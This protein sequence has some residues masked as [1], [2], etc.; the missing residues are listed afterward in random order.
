MIEFFLRAPVRTSVAIGSLALLAG[1]GSPAPRQE[2]RAGAYRIYATNEV[3]G[4]LSIIDPESRSVVGRIPLGKRPRGIMPSPDGRLLYVALSGSPIGGPG[5]AEDSLPPAD[6]AADGIAVIDVA[7]GKVKQVLRGI[8]DPEQ[9]AVSPDG[10]RLYVASEDSGKL[11]VIGA[12]GGVIAKVAVGD[13][14]EGVA[15]SPDGK[16]V[17]VTSEADSAVA[18][19]DADSGTITSHVKVGKRP[20]NALFLPDGGRAWVSGE[21]DG[22]VSLI[23]VTSGRLVRQVRLE[24]DGARPMDI[25]LSPDGK[26]LYVTTGRGKQLVRIDTA[27]FRQTGAVEVGDR[28]WGMKLSPDGRFAFTANGPSNDVSMVD[29]A[30]MRVVARIKAGDRPWAVAAVPVR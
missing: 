27:I 14:P 19:V 21:N 16:R 5:V 8:S 24:G 15:V 13:E 7:S 29:L 22:T 1:C 10:H 11:V 18:I 26:T 20:R 2:E 3:S 23:D 28:P 30:A 9:V 6:K 17:L 25:A 12:T 4:D